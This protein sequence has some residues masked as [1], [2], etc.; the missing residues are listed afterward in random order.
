[1]N[2]IIALESEAVI[3]VWAASCDQGG[4]NIVL[5]AALGIAPKNVAFVHPLD[6]LGFLFFQHDFD[7]KFKP[8]INQ[9][10][11]DTV[12]LPSGFEVLIKDFRVLQDAF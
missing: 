12:T 4:K 2:V 11:D 5:N 1:M 9:L 7:Y 8:F 6:L 3:K 10:L